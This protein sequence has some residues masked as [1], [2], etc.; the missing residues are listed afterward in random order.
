MLRNAGAAAGVCAAALYV[1]DC[2]H[3]HTYMKSYYR[4]RED[5]PQPSRPSSGNVT[6]EEFEHAI[7]E[8]SSEVDDDRLGIAYSVED[9]SYRI[10]RESFVFLAGGRAALLQIAHPFVASGVLAHSD[11]GR[12]GVQARFYRTFEY[13]FAMTYGDKDE[14]IRA[15]RAVR[16]IHNHVKVSLPL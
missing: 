6:A 8:V 4:E 5:A 15:S 1:A 7:S 10:N 11:I 12:R 2:V 3:I 13:I 14:V 9:I 16:S